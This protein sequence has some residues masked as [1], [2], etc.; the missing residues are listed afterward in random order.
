ML[1]FTTLSEI[2]TN[3]TYFERYQNAW[4]VMITLKDTDIEKFN[5]TQQIQEMDEVKSATVY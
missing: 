3:Y 4:D 5:M 1:C 2:S